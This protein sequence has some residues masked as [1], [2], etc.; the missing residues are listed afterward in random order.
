MNRGFIC[1]GMAVL[2]ILC[3]L[4]ILLFPVA[5]GPYPAT[6]GPVTSLEAMRTGFLLWLNIALAG[7]FLL[8][9]VPHTGSLVALFGRFRIYDRLTY[10]RFIQSSSVLRC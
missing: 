3:T 5:S 9:R 6:H 7:L 4:A 1:R 8:P 10:L 2:A